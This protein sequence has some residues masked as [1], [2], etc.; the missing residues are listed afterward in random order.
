MLRASSR[1]LLMSASWGSAVREA[2]AASRRLTS[3]AGF[4]SVPLESTFRVSE[5]MKACWRRIREVSEP[6]P[7]VLRART[8]ARASS[9]WTTCL[10]LLSSRP[11]LE[12]LTS[13]L[14]QISTPP[15]ASTMRLNPPKSTIMKL[16]MFKPLIS[17]TA[18]IVQPGPA[19]SNAALNL[20]S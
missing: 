14:R 16:S 9:P 17:S 11:L 8:K 7:R 15:M 6:S 13:A 4:S 10:P 18:L 5:E 19:R 3:V 2:V 20:A 12:S 1:R